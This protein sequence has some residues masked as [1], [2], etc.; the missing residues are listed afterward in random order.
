M[1]VYVANFSNF[2]FQFYFNM[3]TRVLFYFTPVKKRE[4]NKLAKILNTTYSYAIQI[5][6]Y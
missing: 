4:D 5:T 6:F 1:C 3:V 2:I